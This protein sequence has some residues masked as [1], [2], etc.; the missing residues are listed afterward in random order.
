M[1]NN[2]EEKLKKL[3]FFKKMWYSITNFEKYPYMAAEGVGRA[4]SYL[5][6]ITAIFVIAV[7]IS[8]VYNSLKSVKEKLINEFPEISYTDN[9]LQVDSDTSIIIE[10]EEDEGIRKIVI[11]TKTE[12]EEEI[13]NYLEELETGIL[14][15]KDKIIATNIDGVGGKTEYTYSDV[16]NNLGLNITEFTKKDV[17]DYINSPQIYLI[18]FL[19]MF[20]YLIV[21]Y[22]FTVLID[23]ITLS[24][25]GLITSKFVGLR[26]KYVALFN[27]SVYA[28]T[29][30]IILNIIYVIVNCFIEL[31]IEYFQVAY[32]AIA[33][34]YLI[35]VIFIIKSDFI[36]KQAELMKIIEEQKHNNQTIEIEEKEEKT[37]ET[38]KKENEEDG[39]EEE[40]E[41][42]NNLG[43]EPKGSET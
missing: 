3:N 10:T 33:Y 21:I 5:I 27:M 6:G 38:D 26:M 18:L 12:D 2:E 36:K 31:T 11:D 30:S 8:V 41:K 1:K 13:N 37:K 7:S 20:V 16:I 19:I 40:K 22:I 23:A 34:I 32:I 29:L 42:D 15:L 17:L 14:V 9:Q 35:A 4:I 24:L 25:L 39:K 43:G 28:L